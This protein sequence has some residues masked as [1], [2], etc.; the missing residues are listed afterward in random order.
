M[1]FNE[2][3]FEEFFTTDAWII[4]QSFF[5]QLENKLTEY[6]I[7]H[8]KQKSTIEGLI[9][10]LEEFIENR[11]TDRKINFNDALK[12]LEEI[13]SP[14][15]IIS[16]LEIPQD[17][18]IEQ[19]IQ[20]PNQKLQNIQICLKCQFLNSKDAEFCENCGTNLITKEL[21]VSKIKQSIID[22]PYSFSFI[23]AY[24][25]LVFV[26]SIIFMPNVQNPLYSIV[27]GLFYAS[28]PAPLIA[29]IN[30]WIL[31]YFL[32]EKKS[33]KF[34]YNKIMNDIEI[35]FALGSFLFFLS[36]CLLLLFGITLQL[37][38]V[39]LIAIIFC[40][41][42]FFI[43]ILEAQLKPDNIPYIELLKLKKALEEYTQ[44]KIKNHNINFTVAI[45]PVIIIAIIIIFTYPPSYDVSGVIISAI[46]FIF[47]LYSGFNGILAMYY[48]SWPK[49]RS[50]V[51][52]NLS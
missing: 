26:L 28:F 21:Q 4:I 13:G 49:I 11:K 41:C 9:E 51:K 44:E 38:M 6:K 45:S 31:D 32:K 22:H 2:E 8:S 48:Y 46:M 25:G 10:Y 17:L 5:T 23:L 33:S 15:D 24:I 29:V 16:M 20:S 3:K 18:R 39:V 35:N 19:Q 36:T 12:L 7:P 27:S 30:G 1:I 40:F 37:A 47:S 50:Y 52:N 34:K 42:L 14:S 43:L